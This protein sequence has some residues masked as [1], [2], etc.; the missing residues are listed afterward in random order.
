MNRS[1]TN[2]LCNNT[3]A[4]AR[5]YEALLGMKR[6]FDSDWFIILTH[7]NIAGLEFGLLDKTHETVPEDIRSAPAGVI[8]T[9]VVEDCDQTYA[10]ATELQA[11][12]IEPPT[13]MFY[14]QRRM[15]IRD[16][17]GTVLD[18]SAPTAPMQSM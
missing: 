12:I 18:I 14:G 4:T 16:P 7:E 9:F 8:V 6:H 13:D 5:F 2:I 1:F 3:E 15:L 11:D 10:K 17:E